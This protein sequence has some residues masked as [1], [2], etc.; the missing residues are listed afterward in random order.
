MNRIRVL[1]VEDQALV[2][3][4]LRM[5]LDAQPDLIVAGEAGDGLDAV[6]QVP[7]LRPDV[8]LMDVRMPVLDGIEATRRITALP[9]PPKVLILTTYDLDEHVL[10]AIRAGATGFLLKDAPPEQLLGALR[11]VHDGDAVLAASATRRLL[12]RLAP[13]LDESAVR[14]VATLTA[15]EREILAELGGGRSNAEIAAR[16]TVAEGTVK[17]H[18]SN[19]L[20]KLG[21]RDR[22]QAVVLAYESGVVRP[23]ER[24]TPDR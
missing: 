6:Q 20:T 17:T 16:L 3:A 13:P 10:A 7:R 5:V 12:N 19:V 11:T 1:L 14:A 4:G 9:G 18:V 21:I 22:A 15:R 8:V 2:R 24:G 23:G